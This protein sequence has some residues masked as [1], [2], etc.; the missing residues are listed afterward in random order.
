[1]PCS[2]CGGGESSASTQFNLNLRK[3]KPVKQRIQQQQRQ[4]DVNVWLKRAAQLRAYYASRPKRRK[5]H[6]FT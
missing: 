1:M 5:T 3:F 2:A 4:Q 6:M